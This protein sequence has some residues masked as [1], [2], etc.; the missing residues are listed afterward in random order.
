[1]ASSVVVFSLE[2]NGVK[3]STD[4][5]YIGFLYRDILGREQPETEEERNNW[6]VAM[7]NGR[8]REDVF[9]EFLDSQEFRS[10]Q[11][12]EIIQSDESD[13]QQTKGKEKRKEQ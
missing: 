9:Y 10:G 2:D 8:S 13:R 1:M 3:T 5:E 7:R 4:E 6:I 11:G 12:L